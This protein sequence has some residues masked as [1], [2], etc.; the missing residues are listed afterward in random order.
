MI[1]KIGV[2]IS[3]YKRP[4][5]LA[6]SL[7]GWAVHLDAADELV[8]NHDHRGVGVAAVKNRG[9]AAL[10]DLRCEHLFLAD[11]DIHPVTDRWWRP[12]VDNPQ[13]HLMHCWGKSRY[14][15]ETEDACTVWNWPR[16]VLLYMTRGV[17]ERVG[18]MRLDFGLLGGEHCEYSRRVYRA[19][20]TANQ[21]QDA[22]AARPLRIWHCEDYQRSAATSMPGRYTPEATAARHTLFDK[23]RHSTDFVEYRL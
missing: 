14:L 22:R 6:K 13:P 17:V 21:F 7:A 19:G 5:V 9:L 20:L 1:G 8:V 16:G 23:Y 2:A 18:G 4:D 3:S 10:M 11:S 12:Y 15:G